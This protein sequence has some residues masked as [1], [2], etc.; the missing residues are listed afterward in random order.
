M[1]GSHGIKRWDY[2]FQAFQ[3]LLEQRFLTGAPFGEDFLAFK[4]VYKNLYKTA[5][6]RQEMKKYNGS[7]LKCVFDNFF[8]IFI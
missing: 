1:A 2:W 5:K 7:P 6:D 8:Y 3:A 4:A